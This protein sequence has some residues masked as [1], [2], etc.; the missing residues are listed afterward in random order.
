[1][2]KLVEIITPG[3]YYGGIDES[4]H[5][6]V[7]EVYSLVLSSNQNDIIKN[8]KVMQ[9]RRKSA[10]KPKNFYKT[11]E[12]FRY[13]LLEEEMIKLLG[14]NALKATVIAHLLAAVDINPRRVS[15]YIDG[16]LQTIAV[17]EA[18]MIYKRLT[19]KYLPPK[20]LIPIE[21]GDQWYPIINSTDML[22]YLIYSNLKNKENLPSEDKLV[23]LPLELRC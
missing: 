14:Q 18:T 9:K 12:D 16:F 5:G 10:P 3:F 8:I 20:K 2:I 22:S 19:G 7:P 21:H 1:V 6:K 11:L 4:N 13:L 15:I 17:K 23:I